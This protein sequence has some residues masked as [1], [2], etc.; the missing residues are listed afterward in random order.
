MSVD[1]AILKID[2]T[3]LCAQLFLE[4]LALR[5][6]AFQVSLSVEAEP[7]RH[8]TVVDHRFRCRRLKL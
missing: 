4:L 8:Q 2:N 3:N 7:V 1:T 6:A 5:T